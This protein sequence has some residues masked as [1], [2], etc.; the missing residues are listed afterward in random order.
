MQF[1]KL[2]NLLLSIK[3][4]RYEIFAVFSLHAKSLFYMKFQLANTAFCFVKTYFVYIAI[5]INIKFHF[6]YILKFKN[7]TKNEIN[8]TINVVSGL[9]SESSMLPFHSRIRPYF[10]V[11][12]KVVK[13]RNPGIMLRKIIVEFRSD[14]F[15]L[16]F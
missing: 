11:H 10:R 1:L 5:Q 6:D 7:K 13:N 15:Y 4:Y 14:T 16:Q 3:Y 9:R 12:Y 8:I 2:K